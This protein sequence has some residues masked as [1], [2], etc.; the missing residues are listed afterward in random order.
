L[1]LA[2]LITCLNGQAPPESP[3]Y[4]ITSD[5]KLVL[6][7]VAAR[8]SRGNFI[9]GLRREDF[10]VFDSR[11]EQPIRV[12]SGE[13]TPVTVGL[14]VD[15]SG[16]MRTK[17]S[18]VIKAARAL[19][20]ASNSQDEM[21]VVSF[22]DRVSF[23]LPEGVSFTDDQN[24]LRAAL[25]RSEP[26]GQTALYDALQA[27]LEHLR[28][29]MQDRKTLVLISDGGDTASRATAGQIIRMAQS[30][31]VTIHVVGIYDQNQK[32]RDLGFLK[33]LARITGGEAIV[34]YEVQDLAAA[35]RRIAKDIR[36]RYTIGYRPPETAGAETRKVHI[37]ISTVNQAKLSALT[38]ESYTIPSP[39]ENEP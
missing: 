18:E 3:G 29:G 30:S 10:H 19:I 17:R 1:T 15:S 38:R 26:E 4:K 21:F 31:S 11:R 20:Q 5:V 2:G 16:S 25:A 23:E 37:T 39:R 33:R 7:D 34:E 12:F 8:D 9:S 14:L 13:D 36:S 32:D 35:C 6:L 28:R 27:G 22:G 24:L